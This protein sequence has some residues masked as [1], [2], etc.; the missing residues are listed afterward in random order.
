MVINMSLTDDTKTRLKSRVLKDFRNAL[1]N[2]AALV[3]AFRQSELVTNTRTKSKTIEAGDLKIA[4][5]AL[6]TPGEHPQYT[7]DVGSRLGNTLVSAGYPE[8][9]VRE[10]PLSRKACYESMIFVANK[11]ICAEFDKAYQQNLTIDPSFQRDPNEL[12]TTQSEMKRFLREEI[13]PEII[14]IIQQEEIIQLEAERDN[15]L[16]ISSPQ[17]STRNANPAE[18]ATTYQKFA[19]LKTKP[20]AQD[21]YIGF[22]RATNQYYQSQQDDK[23]KGAYKLACEN[24]VNQSASVLSTHRGVIGYLGNFLKFLAKKICYKALGEWADRLLSTP[25]NTADITNRF[26]AHIDELV[27][28]PNSGADTTVEKTNRHEPR[29]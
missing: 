13:F 22:L 28:S 24:A 21:L 26:K 10:I 29:L 8:A 4:L 7:I 19:E 2:E 11:Q 6:D 12:S 3:D 16:N 1:R 20:W 9:A 15:I 27:E 18:K 14:K 25:T 23:S 17:D 5:E